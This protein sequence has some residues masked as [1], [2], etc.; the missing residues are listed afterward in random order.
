MNREG[1]ILEELVTSKIIWKASSGDSQSGT[2]EVEVAMG[3]FAGANFDAV[4]ILNRSLEDEKEK[5][6][7]NPE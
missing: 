7:E 3:A 5:R 1:H 2:I 4:S 6:Y